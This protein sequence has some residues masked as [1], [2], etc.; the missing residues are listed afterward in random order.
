MRALFGPLPHGVMPGCA[1]FG[2]GEK[3]ATVMREKERG[4]NRNDIL[5]LFQTRAQASSTSDLIQ[6]SFSSPTTAI[7]MGCNCARA[8]PPHE[9]VPYGT[10][11][12][13][14]LISF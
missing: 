6:T 1:V 7:H 12:M 13:H 5:T 10:C 8:M 9:P 2:L 3:R 11:D 4:R 14:R